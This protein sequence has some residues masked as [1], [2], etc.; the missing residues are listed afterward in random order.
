MAGEVL[1]RHPERGKGK[2]HRLGVRIDMTPLV[3]V[4]FLLLTFFMLASTMLRPQAMEIN[5]PD[6]KP[7]EIPQENLL[8][9]R[10]NE[11]GAIFWNI[12][13]DRPQKVG[14]GDLR[15]LLRKEYE[16]NPLITTVVKAARDARFTMLVDII[17]EL[18]LADVTQFSLGPF[19]DE[20]RQKIGSDL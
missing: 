11:N 20:D 19:S 13:F 14:F 5:L 4:A 15:E 18:N 12:G 9:L 7:V 16:K 17:D 2:P 6:K 1:V 10:V 8:I 3:D